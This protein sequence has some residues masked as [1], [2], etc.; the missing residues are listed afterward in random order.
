MSC[1]DDISSSMAL[2]PLSSSRPGLVFTP[3][4]TEPIYENKPVTTSFPTHEIT[5]TTNNTLDTGLRLSGV[6]RKW[7]PTGYVGDVC[8]MTPSDCC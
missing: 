6:T 5:P 1:H 8:M 4:A 2:S 3:Y 7:G